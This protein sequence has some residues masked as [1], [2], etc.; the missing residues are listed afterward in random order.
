[1]EKFKVS[2]KDTEGIVFLQYSE[3]FANSALDWVKNK[4]PFLKQ[5]EQIPYIKLK[6]VLSSYVKTI[7]SINTAINK[8]QE[9]VLNQEQFDNIANLLE[10][11]IVVIEKGASK[12]KKMIEFLKKSGVVTDLEI[13]Q[14][15]EE[16]KEY[17][18]EDMLN[19]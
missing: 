18:Q 3:V 4:I 13:L 2:E 16:L 14:V 12:P 1:M 9:K 7:Y 17:N 19:V 15:K 6:K 8:E 5:D 10:V 11:L